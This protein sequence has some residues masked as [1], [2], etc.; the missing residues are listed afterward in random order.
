V[1]CCRSCRLRC[2]HARSG[3]LGGGRSS[4][5]SLRGSRRDGRPHSR[6]LR[7][8]FFRFLLRF[9]GRFGLRFG[10]GNSPNFLSHLVRD[11]LGNGARVRLFLGDA[12][13][14]QKV[15]DG[16]GL[17]LQFT[18]QFI[19]SDLIRLAHALGLLFAPWFS[20]TPTLPLRSSLRCHRSRRGWLLVR[21]H[22]QRSPF[23][24]RP[25]LQAPLNFLRGSLLPQP[26]RPGL[27]LLR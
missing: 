8:G 3:G 1:R 9:G 7:C 6:S 13:A 11:V 10:F 17:D 21:L 26:S 23:L 2:W 27:L 19:D 15:N 14:G 25:P 12:K 22:K 4:R 24:L 16:F 5:L 18:G 20:V